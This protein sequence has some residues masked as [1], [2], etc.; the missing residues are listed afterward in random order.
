MT[1]LDPRGV[2]VA[3]RWARWHLGDSAWALDIL[4]AYFNPDETERDLDE[5]MGDDG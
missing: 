1:E 2:A 5:E 4:E 3:R